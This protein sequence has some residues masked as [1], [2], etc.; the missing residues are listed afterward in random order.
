MHARDGSAPYENHH[1]SEGVGESSVRDEDVTFSSLTML[2][3]EITSVW[4]RKWPEKWSK[5][6]PQISQGCKGFPYT[7]L[8]GQHSTWRVKPAG[9]STPLIKLSPNLL[10]H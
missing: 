7:E 2:T 1:D 4:Y 8:P 10:A 6:R 9:H 3:S 5:T